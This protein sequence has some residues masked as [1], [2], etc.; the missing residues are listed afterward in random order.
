MLRDTH[1]AGYGPAIEAGTLTVMTS[2]SSWNGV[3]LLAN[4]GLVTNVLK[5]R[6]GFDGS[7]VGD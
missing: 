4:K 5:D 1:G 6:M 3:K 2:F 7:V